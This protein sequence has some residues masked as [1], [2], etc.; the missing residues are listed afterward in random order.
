MVSLPRIL[1][2]FGTR[3][4]AIKMAP[5]VHRLLDSNRLETRICVTA[6]HREMLDQVLS[7][8]GIR[9]NYDLDL[10]QPGQSL[11]QL[12][13]RVLNGMK[14]VLEE[15][16]PHLVLVHGDT[17][18]TF[19]VALAS[20]YQRVPVGHVEAGL[21]THNRYSPFPEEMNRHLAAVLADLHFAPTEKAREN[22]LREGIDKESVFVT[23][24]TAI[25]SLLWMSDRIDQGIVADRAE[26]ENRI[27][28]RRLVL[29]TAH[30][31]ESFGDGFDRICGAL[32]DLTKR[33]SDHIFVYPVH[34]N[35]NVIEPVERHLNG[36]PN[37][38]LIEPLSYAPFVSLMKRAHLILT[39]SG[40]IQ[41]EGPSLGI[42]VLVMRDTTER[43]EAVDAGTVILVGND[44]NRIVEEASR[45][46]END[47]EHAAMSRKLNPYGD[48]HAA[49]RILSAILDG[50]T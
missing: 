21:R 47:Q 20:F 5:V 44:R 36:I 7:V 46:L 19:A 18:T 17:T 40:G 2:T 50:W 26:I 39:D 3:P 6:Q 32:Q 24:N 37:L 38:H 9:P 1:V 41:E 11:H 25:D 22:L 14:P 31:R 33:F 35:P 12:T 13:G 49:D 42:P 29:I 30:R 4:E 10:M 43:P 48:G 34:P 28:G 27:G 16:D 15:F 23:G 45:L 8:F